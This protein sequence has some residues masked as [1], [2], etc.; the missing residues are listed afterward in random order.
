MPVELTFNNLI[1]YTEWERA[2]WRDWFLERGD[3]ALS[4]STGPHGDSRL[5]TVGEVIRHIFS[6]EKRYIDRLW[7][8]PITET[9]SIPTD[10]IAALFQFGQLSRKC[11]I[12]FIARLPIEDWDR[13]Q[14]F[15]LMNSTLRATHKK[16]VV[17]ILMHEIRHWAQIATM[18][19][20]SGLPLG[21]FH[22]FLFSP[23]FGGELRTSQA[24]SMKT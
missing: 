13:M 20:F 22:D 4:V 12:E 17:H 8:R 2:R 14:E 10:D 6:A 21:E 1:E 3:K 11:L 24:Q 7:G 16:V 23:V 5:Q 15:P 19:R 18:L 9:S